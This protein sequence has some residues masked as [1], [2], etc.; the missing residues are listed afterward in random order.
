MNCRDILNLT[1]NRKRCR[2][3]IT[4]LI[5]D[6]ASN[7]VLDAAFKIIYKKRILYSKTLKSYSPM[8]CLNPWS[9]TKNFTP[10]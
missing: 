7:K 3:H 1:K 9:S 8:T 10:T 6:V 5:S 4:N 2:H